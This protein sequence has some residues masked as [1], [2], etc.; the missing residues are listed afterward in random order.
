[1]PRLGSYENR[2]CSHFHRL[3]MHGRSFIDVS[4]FPRGVRSVDRWRPLALALLELTMSARHENALPSGAV[5]LGLRPTPRRPSRPAATP[6]IA[7][8]LQPPRFLNNHARQEAGRTCGAKLSNPSRSRARFGR[9]RTGQLSTHGHRGRRACFPCVP[10]S[11]PKGAWQ[12]PRR[13]ER[14]EEMREEYE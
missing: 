5:P 12:K 11:S 6:Q 1:M 9:P 3:G 4:F 8:L 14:C 10:S 2:L 7:S 13:A